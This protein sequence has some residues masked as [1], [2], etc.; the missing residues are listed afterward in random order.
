MINYSWCDCDKLQKLKAFCSPN[1]EFLTINAVL[2][3]KTILIG[4][5]HSR[6]YFPQA[7]TTTALKELH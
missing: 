7:D 6:V 2:P 1:L 5:S 4:Y 3:L